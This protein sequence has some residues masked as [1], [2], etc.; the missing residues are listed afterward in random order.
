MGRLVILYLHRYQSTSVCSR[1]VLW[2]H[3]P[4]PAIETTCLVL[5]LSTFVA[6]VVRC[7]GWTLY[8][9]YSLARLSADTSAFQDA[10]VVA[11]LSPVN[12]APGDGLCKF[13]APSSSPNNNMALEGTIPQRASPRSPNQNRPREGT[14]PLPLL[15]PP[16]S[17]SADPLEL[18]DWSTPTLQTFSGTHY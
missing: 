7:A 2:D 16:N 8:C 1:L 10:S 6:D 5:A 12:W 4:S 3:C 17:P 11:A 18:T 9:R 14:L 13:S 15:P